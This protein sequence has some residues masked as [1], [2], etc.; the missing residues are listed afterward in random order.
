MTKELARQYSI[1]VAS[2][3]NFDEAIHYMGQI[4][5][6]NNIINEVEFA[7]RKMIYD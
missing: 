5:F 4:D 6:I 3:P 2:I 1:I 7:C